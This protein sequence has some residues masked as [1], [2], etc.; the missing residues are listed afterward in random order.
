[1]ARGGVFG[2][3]PPPRQRPLSYNLAPHRLCGQYEVVVPRRPALPPASWQI[4][5]MG[6]RKLGNAQS[7]PTYTALTIKSSLQQR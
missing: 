7:G 4:P 1:G 3:G 2:G 5:N 6:Q